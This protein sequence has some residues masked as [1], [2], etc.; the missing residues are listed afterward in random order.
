MDKI[1]EAEIGRFRCL[2][3]SIW[4]N[5]TTLLMEA[6]V[7]GVL[8]LLRIFRKKWIGR[9][10]PRFQSDRNARKTSPLAINGRLFVQGLER[11]AAID[12]Y[13]GTFLW[14][15]S[16]PDFRRFNVPRDCSNWS[17]DDGFL[18]TAVGKYCHKVD[19]AT[20]KAVNSIVVTPRA[21]TGN[22]F[23]WGYIAN[24]D[25][26]IIGSAVKPNNI[27]TEFYRWC[28]LV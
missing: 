12:S 5:Q 16:Q 19:A 3:T 21:N 8:L 1:E 2:V 20:G 25:G 9:P 14:T 6:K 23:D 13:N 17:A 10:G 15:N 26:Q 4:Q 11:I 24:I 7:Y 28:Q 27:Y 22:Q 18:Y